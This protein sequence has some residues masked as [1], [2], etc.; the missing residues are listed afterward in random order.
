M[1]VA[2]RIGVEIISADSGQV[3]RGLDIGTAKPTPEERRGIPYHLIDILNPDAIFSAEDFRRLAG[4]EIQN[5]QSRGKRVLVVGGT[6]LYLKAL[7][8]GLFEGPS[9]DPAVRD[10][11]EKRAR[12]E[13]VESLKKELASIDPKAAAQIPGNNRQRLIRALEVYRLTGRPIS[14]HWEAHRKISP[15]TFQKIGINLPQEELH[16]RIESRVDRMIAQGL[17][18]EVRSLVQKWGA[19]AP[20]LKIIGYKE[21]VAHLSGPTSLKEAVEWIK[22]HTRQYAKRQMTWFRKDKEIRWVSDFN[23]EIQ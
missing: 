7:E 14:E 4:E 10:E 13:G 1:T 17:V 2:E 21:I 8:G 11:L 15:F 3:Y 20:A 19:T 12:E 5:I 16:R 9:R 6:G 18:D 22:I 23:K